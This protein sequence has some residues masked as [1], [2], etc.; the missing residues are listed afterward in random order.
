[1]VDPEVL[2][3]LTERNKIG[4]FGMKVLGM[5]ERRAEVFIAACGDRFQYDGILQ[6]KGVNGLVP[7]DDPSCVGFFQ[8]EYDFLLPPKSNGS[9]KAPDVPA[10]VLEKALAGNITAIGAVNRIRG[11][12]DFETTKKFLAGERGRQYDDKGKFVSDGGNNPWLASKW[13][14]SQ[15]MSIYKSDPKLAENLMR[16]A[17]VTL[18]A[19]HPAKVSA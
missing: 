3:K 11:D 13:D 8:R 16:R 2:R 6:F 4:D 9:D 17:G 15:Q 1:M 19:A 12:A 5:D 18:G 10:D 7:V 14:L